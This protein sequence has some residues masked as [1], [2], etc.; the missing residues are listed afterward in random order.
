M[1]HF[2]LLFLLAIL[3]VSHGGIPGAIPHLEDAH[4]HEVASTQHAHDESAGAVF[5]VEAA[6]NS[7]A[8]G[9]L[10]P[11][12]ASHS[13]S[14]IALPSETAFSDNSISSRVLLR[15]GAASPLVGTSSAPLTQP[16]SA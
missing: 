16:P 2:R 11:H 4:T 9:E 12:G 7:Y 14:S 3:L 1:R 8:S 13:H 10:A 5:K 15:P 6:V